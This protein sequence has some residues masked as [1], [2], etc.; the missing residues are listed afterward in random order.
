MNEKRKR[1]TNSL[2]GFGMINGDYDT[3]SLICSNMTI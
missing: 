2:N 1:K 3:Q